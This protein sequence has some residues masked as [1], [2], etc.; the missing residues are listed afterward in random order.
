MKNKHHNILWIFFFVWI[1][2]SGAG[3]GKLQCLGQLCRVNSACHPQ[4]M[5]DPAVVSSYSD[6]DNC[7]ELC[8][9]DS[10]NKEG[11]CQDTLCRPVGSLL[12]SSRNAHTP[13]MDIEGPKCLPQRVMDDNHRSNPF[14]ARHEIKQPVPIYT[15]VQAFLC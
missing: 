1:L 10:Q 13:Q 3:Y 15:L 5:Y 14:F 11:D 9:F 8:Y 7:S 12:I 4:L 6:W 2:V